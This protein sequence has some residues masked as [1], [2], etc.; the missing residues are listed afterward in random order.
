MSSKKLKLI[1]TINWM[2]FWYNTC[3]NPIFNHFILIIIIIILFI[4]KDKKM[5]IMIKKQVKWNKWKMN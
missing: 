3:H 2:I 4:E 5:M 1:L